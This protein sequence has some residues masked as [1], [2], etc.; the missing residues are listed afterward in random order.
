[1]VDLTTKDCRIVHQVIRRHYA[2]VDPNL[3]AD[4]ESAGHLGLARA[5]QRWTPEGGAS[6][7]NYAFLL[8]RGAIQDTLREQDY[9][10]RSERKRVQQGHGVDTGPIE[11][12]YDPIAWSGVNPDPCD[13]YAHLDNVDLIQWAL[14]QLPD[15]WRLVVTCV[16][17][18]GHTCVN[19]AE[20]LGV[21]E[22]RVSQIRSAAHRRMRAL[23]TADKWS[24]RAV[25]S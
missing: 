23:I 20:I 2:L 11:T 4:M 6:F 1:M 12:P 10:T 25:T 3:H 18:D 19:V 5:A 16:D 8:V 13:E 9:L 24:A 22:S 14:R 17:L 15:K 21:T 7:R